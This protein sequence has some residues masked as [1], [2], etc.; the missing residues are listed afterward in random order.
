MD[1]RTLCSTQGHIY[2][3]LPISLCTIIPIITIVNNYLYQQESR[4]NVSAYD[5]C[6]TTKTTRAEL[7]NFYE[8][9]CD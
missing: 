6:T 1:V 7:D 8:N 4:G 3:I 2:S 5:L 9:P